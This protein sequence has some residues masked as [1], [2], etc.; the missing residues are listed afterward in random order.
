MIAVLVVLAGALGA[1]A[2]FAVDSAVARRW[3]TT[4]SWATVGINVSGSFLLGML[5]GAVA[6]HSAPDAW[7]TVVGTGFCGGYTTFGTAMVQAARLARS[8]RTT[9]AA[10][11]L[12]VTL[13]ASVVACAGGFTVAASV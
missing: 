13:G 8:G 6:L 7:Q 9:A 2:R 4:I 1:V 12:A 11:G 5:A 10:V 3:S